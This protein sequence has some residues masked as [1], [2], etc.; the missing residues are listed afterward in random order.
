MAMVFNEPKE[1]IIFS[2]RS[3]QRLL[4]LRNFDISRYVSIPNVS[5]GFL[6][7]EADLIAVSKSGYAHEVEIKVS[8]ADI[9]NEVKKSDKIGRHNSD[10]NKIAYFYFAGPEFLK[11][12]F[13]KHAPDHWGILC[14]NNRGFISYSRPAKKVAGPLSKEDRIKLYRLG[15]IRYW[16]TQDKLEEQKKIAELYRTKLEESN[17]KDNK[18]GELE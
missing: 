11:E 10:R 5:Y 4:V 18:Q 7:Y 14:F 16:N 2:E 8:K 12:D 1:Q 6:P 3:I 13:E 9:L 15:V 17:T